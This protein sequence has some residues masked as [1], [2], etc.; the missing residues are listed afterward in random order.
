[1]GMTREVRNDL[2][3]VSDVRLDSAD[4]RDAVMDSVVIIFGE[5]QVDMDER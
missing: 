4:T 2:G 1:M 5:M 3:E